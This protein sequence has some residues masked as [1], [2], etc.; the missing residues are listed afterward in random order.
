[1]QGRLVFSFGLNHSPD[2][3]SLLFPPSEEPIECS[4]PPF[5]P[6]QTLC[7]KKKKNNFTFP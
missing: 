7:Q 3:R 5:L 4:I 1:M 2:N 6:V